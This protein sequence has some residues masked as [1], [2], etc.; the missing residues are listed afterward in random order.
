MDYNDDLA[1]NLN[2]VN[3][4]ASALV[5]EN[6]HLRLQNRS[7]TEQLRELRVSFEQATGPKRFS[8]VR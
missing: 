6:E 5:M 1:F 3:G 7:L 4:D 2:S 8:G